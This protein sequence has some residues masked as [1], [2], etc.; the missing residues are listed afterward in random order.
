MVAWTECSVRNRQIIKGKSR[1]RASVG[2]DGS[3]GCVDPHRKLVRAPG[4][5]EKWVPSV[6]SCGSAGSWPC[7][8]IVVWSLLVP[9]AS[10]P[11]SAAGAK[12]W[13]TA[14]SIVMLGW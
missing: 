7:V 6:I 14:R 4:S 3:H 1:P 11:H 8:S 13:Q 10:M 2:T 9:S 5:V 12:R